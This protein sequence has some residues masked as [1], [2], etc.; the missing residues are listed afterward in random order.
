MKK[1]CLQ[2][3]KKFLFITIPLSHSNPIVNIRKN[4]ADLQNNSIFMLEN[5]SKGLVQDPNFI[6][7]IG[8]KIKRV[9]FPQT[10]V[11]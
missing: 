9:F 10:S 8:N 2:S 3:R 6:T 7:F 4:M 5:K 11:L 1:V